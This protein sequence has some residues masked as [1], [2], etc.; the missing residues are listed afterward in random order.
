[1]K[2]R[3]KMNTIATTLRDLFKCI[4]ITHSEQKVP[5]DN[6]CNRNEHTFLYRKHLMATSNTILQL[7]YC[8]DTPSYSGHT[9]TEALHCASNRYPVRV[10]KCG[11]SAY[12][13]HTHY[14][15]SDISSVPL[16]RSWERH[17]CT[18]PTT[19]FSFYLSTTDE[20]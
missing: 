9:H 6:T 2:Q 20:C 16:N 10:T 1:M 7:H 15:D 19:L 13:S 14:G 12:P 17:V 8:C 18:Q 5:F 4:C 11:L 3:P